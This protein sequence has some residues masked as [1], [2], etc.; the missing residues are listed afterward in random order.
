MMKAIREFAKKEEENVNVK[1][2]NNGND[3]KANAKYT[4]EEIEMFREF[5][6]ENDT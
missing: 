4:E 1:K 6:L 5:T 2:D 3:R